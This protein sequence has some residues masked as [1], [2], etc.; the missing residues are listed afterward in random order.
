MNTTSRRTTKLTDQRELTEA[1][2]VFTENLRDTVV[3]SAGLEQAITGTLHSCPEAIEPAVRRLVADLRYG[4]LEEAL[5]CFA[6]NLAHPA[7]DFVVAALLSSVQNQTRDL[8]GL[9]TQLS[10][11]ARE[12]CNVYLRVWVSRARTRSAVRIV[13]ASLCVF[14]AGLLLL[15]RSYLA[16]YAT[17]SGLSVL[18]AV[19]GGFAWGLWLLDRMARFTPPARLI[20][21]RVETS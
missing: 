3:S 15:D 18:L 20:R 2:A 1:I 7:S 6:D 19:A 14:V 16:P 11:S 5:R 9:L 4:D 17:V 8:S 13:T 10:R 21:S 12:E